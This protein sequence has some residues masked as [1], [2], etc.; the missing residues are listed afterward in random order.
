MVHESHSLSVFCINHQKLNHHDKIFDRAEIQRMNLN[1][2]II[3]VA[4]FSH[5]QLTLIVAFFIS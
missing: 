1:L 4:A 5:V 2:I 3:L